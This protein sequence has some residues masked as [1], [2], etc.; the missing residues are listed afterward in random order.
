MLSLYRATLARPPVP[1]RNP[2]VVVA[3]YGTIY[4]TWRPHASWGRLGRYA[5][6][7]ARIPI[8]EQFG[9]ELLGGTRMPCPNTDKVADPWLYRTSDAFRLR[10]VSQGDENR[11]RYTELHCQVCDYRIMVPGRPETLRAEGWSLI[12]HPF[13]PT[14]IYGDVREASVPNATTGFDFA[15][16]CL[17][18]V[19]DGAVDVVYG[20]RLRVT[21]RFLDKHLGP[22]KRSHYGRGVGGI[23]VVRAS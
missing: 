20:S 21:D 2:L 8:D 10:A 19:D 17:V 9:L 14:V 16:G 15:R 3:V 18:R 1:A 4:A 5:P 11:K 6:T 7:Y 12:R 13:G 23:Y 22:V